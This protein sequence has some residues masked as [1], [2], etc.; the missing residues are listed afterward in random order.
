[1]VGLSIKQRVVCRYVHH[2][3]A[4]AFIGA[5][6]QGFQLNHLDG[7][8]ANNAAKNLEYTTPMQNIHHAIR[9]GLFVP[10]RKRGRK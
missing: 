10:T 7:V 8:K 4:E 1:M 6:P 3:V 9:L 2:L 5:R